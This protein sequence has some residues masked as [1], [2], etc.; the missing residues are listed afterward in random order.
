MSET[1]G[2]A[3]QVLG[4]QDFLQLLVTQLRHQDPLKPQ[5]NSQFIAQLAQFSALE[6]S[7][8]SGKDTAELLKQARQTRAEALMGR[9]VMDGAGVTATV[10]GVE[11]SA[12]GPILVLD[13]GSSATLDGI[14]AVR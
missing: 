1:I 6:Q 7:V 10:V 14:Q 11:S 3:G 2:P 8:S 12:S 9:K 4:K 13:N 5:D